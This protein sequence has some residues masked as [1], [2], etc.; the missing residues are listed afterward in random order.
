MP[1]GVEARSLGIYLRGNID[2]GTVGPSSGTNLGCVTLD[3][4]TPFSEP[5]LPIQNQ[6]TGSRG[7]HLLFQLDFVFACP[8]WMLVMPGTSP[9]WTLDWEKGRSLWEWPAVC[10]QNLDFALLCVTPNLGRT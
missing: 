9:T 10:P 8:A 1:E 7:S 3:K 4:S 6:R 5:P 2:P